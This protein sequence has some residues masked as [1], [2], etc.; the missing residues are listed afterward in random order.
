[1]SSRS[2][3]ASASEKPTSA[4]PAA[5]TSSIVSTPASAMR[6]R[7]SPSTSPTIVPIWSRTRARCLRSWPRPGWRASIAAQCARDERQFEQRVHI[8]NARAQPVV[9]VVIVVGDVVGDRRDLR[10]EARPACQL[11]RERRVGLGHRPGRLRHR[12][13]MLGEAF[14]RLPAQIE[15]VEIGIRR[16]QPRHE[17]QRVGIVVEPAGVGQRRGQRLL[18]AM[19]ERRMAEVVGEAQGFGQILVEARAR[20]QSSARS[21]R[22]RCCGSAGPGNG[23]RR[24]R[25]TP[26]SCGAGGGRRPNGRCGRGRAGRCRAGRAGRCRPLRWALPRDCAW[27]RGKVLRWKSVIWVGVSRS[28]G[29]WGW[30][31]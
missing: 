31:S 21:A 14:E 7:V 15:P 8:E 22:L 17:P 9:D 25:R 13:I 4:R 10:F 16:L 19:A 23:R 26:G 12:P 20:A 6:R 18:A 1:M 24:A 3:P 11:E 2:S 27:L 29:R 30:S 28:P 5:R